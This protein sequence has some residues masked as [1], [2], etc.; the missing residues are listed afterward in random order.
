[1]YL[2]THNVKSCKIN[3]QCSEDMLG[4]ERRGLIT[5]CF[6]GAKRR[7]LSIEP[8]MGWDGSDYGSLLHSNNFGE[9]WVFENV[10]ICQ[11]KFGFG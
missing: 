6:P 11:G 9:H 4:K 7:G 10:L 1:M 8:W 3:A 5:F 2:I